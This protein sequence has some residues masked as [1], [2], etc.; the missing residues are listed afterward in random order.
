MEG[1]VPSEFE[2]KLIE[3]VETIWIHC[4]NWGKATAK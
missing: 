4:P 3:T 1:M 2:E